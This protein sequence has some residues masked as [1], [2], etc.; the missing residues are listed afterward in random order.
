MQ[1]RELREDLAAALRWAAR[2]GLHEGVDNHFSI[3]VPGPDGE[4]RGERFLINPQ[5]MHWATV[6]AS[7]IVLCDGAGNVLEGEH[8][9]EQTAFCIHSR[10]HIGQPRARV[11]LHTHMPYAT[12]LAHLRGGRL[13]MCGQTA[14]MF[15]GRL[16]YDDGFHGLAL[17]SAEGDRMAAALGAA[18]TLF[19]GGHGV[20]VT[21]PDMARAFTDLYYLERA[22]MVQ[23]LACSHGGELLQ[24]PDDVRA[25]TR[26]QVREDLPNV[27]RGYFAEIRRVLAAEEPD[28]LQ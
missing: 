21:G 5:R 27:A 7:D 22:C 24:V 9:V 8:E 15:D 14:L 18:D 10:V 6:R 16:A 23:V 17:D 12:A 11:A 3:A 19:L 20:L 2:E 1:H 13:A 25:R 26:A 4:V 28:Y